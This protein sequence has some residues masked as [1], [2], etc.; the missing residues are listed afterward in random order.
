MTNYVLL[1]RDGVIN[2]DCNE[3]IKSPSEWRA[4]DGSLE[5]IA[6]LNQHGFRTV[7]ISNQSGLARG[8]FDEAMLERMAQTVLTDPVPWLRRISAPTLL[9]WGE[10]DAM[11]PVAHADDYTAAIRA[12]TLV[13]LPDVGHL[14]QEE[15][16]ERSLRA[17]RAFLE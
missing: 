13:R 16:P 4:I 5:A 15:A 1:D 3:F 6:L 2:H 7:V 10:Q 12:V 17:L 9:L 14:P 11:I 8:L